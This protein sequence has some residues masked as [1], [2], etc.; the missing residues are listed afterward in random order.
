M[1]IYIY[2]YIY[3]NIC[4][5]KVTVTDTVASALLLPR[6]NTR[7]RSIK[8]LS[9]EAP[10]QK[11]V[12]SESLAPVGGRTLLGAEADVTGMLVRKPF[13][14]HANGI[15]PPLARKSASSA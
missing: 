8:R 12:A 6:K 7:M 1:L 4:F 10:E 2:I 11:T 9:S 3:T 5:I 14:A 13:C 15:L